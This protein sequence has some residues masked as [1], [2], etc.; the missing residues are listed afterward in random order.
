MAA[1]R[2]FK[3]INTANQE[4]QLIQANIARA[5]SETIN[6]ALLNGLF[7]ENLSISTTNTQVAHKLGRVPKGYIVI[8]SNAAANV[9]TIDKDTQ[10]ITLKATANCVVNL[11]IF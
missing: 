8:D 5:I 10:F 6:N 1:P 4:L 2:S 9:Y 11:Y 3:Q 7:L